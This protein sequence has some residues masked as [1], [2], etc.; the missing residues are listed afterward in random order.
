MPTSSKPRMSGFDPEKIHRYQPWLE[1]GIGDTVVRAEDFDQ[2]LEEYR[3]LQ[4]KL[5]LLL[6]SLGE[7]L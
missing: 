1:T 2:L 3:D 6:L 7:D 5:N 4:T